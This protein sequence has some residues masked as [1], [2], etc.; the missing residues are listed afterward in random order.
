MYNSSNLPCKGPHMFQMKHKTSSQQWDSL[1][2]QCASVT[3]VKLRAET[4]EGVV[5]LPAGLLALKQH[6]VWEQNAL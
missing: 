4:P 3:V 2:L 1:Q 6:G 5:I